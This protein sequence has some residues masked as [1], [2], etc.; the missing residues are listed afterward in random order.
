V[1][2]ANSLTFAC[3]QA[4][5]RPE[6]AGQPAGFICRPGIGLGRYEGRGWCGFDRQS[7]LSIAAYRFLISETREYFPS[8]AHGKP[9]L[10]QG[11][12]PIDDA[13]RSAHDLLRRSP[14]TW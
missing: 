12:G 2:K 5:Q 13:A 11:G 4:A 6:P 9:T 8:P 1:S 7:N 10:R 14:F 3:H